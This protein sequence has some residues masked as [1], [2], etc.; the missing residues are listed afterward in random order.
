MDNTKQ[1]RSLR[2]RAKI[3]TV[4]VNVAADAK[5]ASRL[6]PN[7]TVAQAIADSEAQL[8]KFTANEARLLEQQKML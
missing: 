7:T 4:T 3:T 6:P 8:A 5:I 2:R 1:R